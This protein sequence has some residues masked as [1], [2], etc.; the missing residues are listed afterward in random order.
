MEGVAQETGGP[1]PADVE[2]VG[3]VLVEDGGGPAGVEVVVV[4][5]EWTVEVVDVF[6]GAAGDEVPGRHWLEW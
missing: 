5:V 6:G 4:V 2:D 1:V 3:L